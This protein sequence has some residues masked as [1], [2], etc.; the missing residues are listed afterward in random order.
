MS[1]KGGDKGSPCNGLLGVHGGTLDHLGLPGF[2]SGQATADHSQE[3]LLSSLG[4]TLS[5]VKRE[6]ST[7]FP[8]LTEEQRDP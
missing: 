4:S 2:S 8:G 3:G 6:D 1:P 5:S 7:C